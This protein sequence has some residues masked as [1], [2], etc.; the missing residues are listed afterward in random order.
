MAAAMW[1]AL[2]TQ[3]AFGLGLGNINLKSSLNQPLQAEVELLSASEKDLQELKVNLGSPE[4]FQ[5]AGIDRLNFLGKLKFEAIRKPDGVAVISITSRE[6][7]REPFLDFL[8][9]VI[10]ANG[11]LTREF[12]VLVD[13]P[14]TMPAPAPATQAP[15]TSAPAPMP[16]R[17]PAPRAVAS[18]SVPATDVGTWTGDTYGPTGR[19]DTLWQIAEKVRPDNNVTMEQTMLGLLNANPEAFIGH[20]INNL[21]AGYVLRVPDR[22]E[23][24]GI[25]AADA[26]AEARLQNQEWREGKVR[27][28]STAARP[29]IPAP[30]PSKLELT[31]PGDSPASGSAVTA[32]ESADLG[33]LR[34]ELVLATE[35]A[36]VQRRQSEEMESRLKALEDQI[37]KMQ[38]LI[39][40]KDDQLAL[41]NQ[42]AGD[43][44]AMPAAAMDGDVEEAAPATGM[45]ADAVEA[46]LFLGE[47]TAPEEPATEETPAVTGEAPV[48]TPEVPVVQ[49]PQEVIKS[50]P[51]PAPAP[52]PAP[53]EESQSLIDRI[54]ANPLWI[55][56][57]LVVLALL[58]LMGLRRRAAAEPEFQESILQER[59]ARPTQASA[60]VVKEQP[61][62]RKEPEMDSAQAA[63]ESDSSLLSEF[64]TSDLGA[65][66]NQSEADPL[67]EADVYLAYG[68]YQQAEDLIRQALDK[69]PDREDL[70]LKLFEVYAAAQN[71]SG[72]D[73]HAE[74]VLARLES[75]DNPLWV[76]AAEMGREL[77][78]GNPLYQLGGAA[79]AAV[80]A[81][82][83]ADSSLDFDLDLGGATEDLTSQEPPLDNLD[84][85]TG[86]DA[87]KKPAAEESNELDFDLGDLNLDDDLETEPEPMADL[88]ADEEGGDGF[89]SDLDEVA[90]KLDLARAY[91]DMGDP[92]GARSILD[93]VVQ[94][95]NEAQKT[96]AEELLKQL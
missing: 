49:A 14:V 39:E 56:V 6:S 82:E 58:A 79:S 80:A 26:S 92:D 44:A 68:R 17:A 95:G 96:E 60:P 43:D 9:E 85:D 84:F 66:Q 23:L 35:A 34:K 46:E 76:R 62:A 4:A 65:I 72:F 19:N 71:R 63:E 50:E 42:Q 53:F 94:E 69:A 13:P 29:T 15:R 73:A 75:Q 57:G 38:R 48:A 16:A 33:T 32:G 88:G 87:E 59:E 22:A 86:L 12:T 89:L 83:P 61:K 37:A 52:A 28:S 90:T 25:S 93:E 5:S 11:K 41:L 10:W 21:K 74:K 18:K 70:N 78:P 67:A 40:L 2:A 3:S 7:V 91:V 81:S 64:A 31:T 1:G 20:N 45:D 77:S 8:L 27:P 36:D 55:G 30:A 54:M 47:G 24:T 51:A